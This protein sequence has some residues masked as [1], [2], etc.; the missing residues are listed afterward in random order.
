MKLDALPSLDTFNLRPCVVGERQCVLVFPPHIGTKWDKD[1]LIFRSSIW[2]IQTL[3]PVSL[4]FKKFFNW[5]EQPDLAP[6][7]D[8]LKNVDII[9]KID[10]STLIVSKYNGQLI[11]RTRGTIDASTLDNGFELEILK[12]KYPA[13]FKSDGLVEDRNPDVKITWDYSL[14]F[15]WVT[16][17]NKIVIN[18]GAEPELYLVAIINHEDYSLK[19][20]DYLDKE[21]VRLGVKRPRRFKFGTF[22]EMFQAINALDY[23]KTR[24]FQSPV[25]M[26]T[27]GELKTGFERDFEGFC[28]YFRNGQEIRKV[29]SAWYLA[30]HKLKSELSSIDKVMDLWATLNY[31]TF[32]E[33][34]D[35]IQ[36]N[37]DYEIAEASRGFASRICEAKKEVDGIIDGM[38]KFVEKIR[39][40]G[41]AHGFV[42]ARA[43]QAKEIFSAY[44]NT[45]RAGYL[46]SIL[47]GKVL[48]RD[49]IKKLLYQV[50]K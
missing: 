12:E 19:T 23:S 37:F 15:E 14:I 16:P 3:K 39:S 31:P 20:Q 48:T 22:E 34:Y 26:N 27:T 33:F 50:M 42:K 41:A 13:I 7:P 2:D 21:A 45:N 30:L 44:G 17:N 24:E 40:L 36:A 4:G 10:G 49:Q 32:Q 43:L 11:A 47:D 9:E 25:D 8:S 18:Y 46:F 28:V 35:Y 29:K 1:N 5:G 38:K 6:T